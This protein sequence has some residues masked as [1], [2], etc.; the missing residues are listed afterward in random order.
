MWFWQWR[1]GMGL[2]LGT[3]V[4]YISSDHFTR[5]WLPLLILW[6]LYTLVNHIYRCNPLPS[7]WFNTNVTWSIV[8]E[9][10][11]KFALVHSIKK[12]ILRSVIYHIKL[13]NEELFRHSIL[14]CTYLY[15]NKLLCTNKR[16]WT[17]STCKTLLFI[18][19]KS[20]KLYK[21]CSWVWR[22]GTILHF[23]GFLC[24]LLGRSYRIPKSNEQSIKWMEGRG[25]WIVININF[26][27]CYLTHFFKWEKF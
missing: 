13:E 14:Y 5:T 21:S 18:D 15:F 11:R 9:V 24:T 25:Q 3:M 12:F 26:H 7:S 8:S 16:C 20:K 17:C 4:R 1:L 10:T 27:R 23:W 19:I 2:V 6:T 22:V